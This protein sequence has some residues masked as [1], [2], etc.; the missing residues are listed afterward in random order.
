[1]NT[2]GITMEML[3][4]CVGAATLHEEVP[5]LSLAV[6]GTDNV[7]VNTPFEA[8]TW[9]DVS[10]ATTLTCGLHKRILDVSVDGESVLF[11]SV[12]EPVTTRLELS[13]GY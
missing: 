4:S 11:H 1:M 3:L 13:V 7:Q 5:R 2:E 9:V 6:A 8:V 10:Q 12:C